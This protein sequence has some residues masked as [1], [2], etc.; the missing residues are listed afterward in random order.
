VTPVTE[1]AGEVK[2]TRSELVNLR[3]DELIKIARQRDLKTS[4]TKRDL[5]DRILGEET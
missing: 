2:Y 5:I 4:G 1:Q 3:K